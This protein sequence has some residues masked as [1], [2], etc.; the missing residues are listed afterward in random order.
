MHKSSLAPVLSA[1]LSR[2][3]CWIICSPPSDRFPG[4][5]L[6]GTRMMNPL[7]FARRRPGPRARGF[8]ARERSP[9]GWPEGTDSRQ[10]AKRTPRGPV[11][12]NRYQRLLNAASA[13]CPGEAEPPR[14]PHR[15]GLKCYAFRGQR[16]KTSLIEHVRHVSVSC[17]HR[18]FSEEFTQQIV[19][20]VVEKSRP[21]VC[22]VLRPVPVDRFSRHRNTANFSSL[23]RI[24]YWSSCW[25]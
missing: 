14:A 10:L 9:P 4:P 11:R 2:D 23:R 22:Q 12:R 25:M 21:M 7:D 13:G 3:S 16:R 20:E 15:Q 6:V 18:E 17:Q 5:G 1:T 24:R 8:V 19:M